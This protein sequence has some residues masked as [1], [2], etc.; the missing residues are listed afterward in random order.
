MF[1]PTS[2]W[3]NL[4]FFSLQ[5][6]NVV[7]MQ[8]WGGAGVNHVKRDWPEI[9]NVN[10]DLYIFFYVKRDRGYLRETWSVIYIQRDPWLRHPFPRENGTNPPK[11]SYLNDILLMHDT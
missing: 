7:Y 10:C 4:N 3:P 2:T 6:E 1:E 8:W 9:F 5:L 11:F